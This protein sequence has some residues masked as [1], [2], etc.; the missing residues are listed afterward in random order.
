MMALVKEALKRTARW[1]ATIAALALLSI[2]AGVVLPRL[3]RFPEKISQRSLITIR[4]SG[5]SA[6]IVYDG[7]DEEQS[8]LMTARYIANLLGHFGIKPEIVRA[9]DYPAGHLSQFSAAF[10]IASAFYGP[11]P[12][13]LI[14]DAARSEKRICWLNRNIEQL[15]AEPG[16]AEKLGF[17]FERYV[18]LRGDVSVLFKGRALPK[19]DSPINIVS[20]TNPSKAEVLAL[21]RNGDRSVPY[22]IKSGN[23]WYFADAVFS[24]TVEADRSLVFSETLHDILGQQHGSS[25]YALVRI[26]DVNPESDPD[27]LRAVA[28]LLF[29]RGIPF[30]VSLIPIYKNPSRLV[31]IYL[32]DRPRVVEALQ[33]MVSRG[34][35]I[36]LHGVTHQLHGITSDDFEFWDAL[37][38]RP[39]REPG[40]AIVQKLDLGMEE[41]FRAGVFPIAWET[42]HYAASIST[43]ELLQRFFSHVY[44]RRMVADDRKTAQDLPY[45]IEDIYGQWVIPENLGYVSLEEPDPGAIVEGAERMLC[46]RDSIPSFFFHPFV[47]TSYLKTIVDGFK[48]HGYRF[49]SAEDFGCSVSIGNYAVS[50]V[51]KTVSIAA[52]QPFSRRITIDA[53]GRTSE[54]YEKVPPGRIVQEKLAPPPG[55]LAAVQDVPK[56]PAPKP[57]PSFGE[58]MRAWWKGTDIESIPIPQQVARRALLVVNPPY[59]DNSEPIDIRSFESFLRVYGIR[60]ERVE[61]SGF[62]NRNLGED[63]VVFVPHSAAG[64]FTESGKRKLAE[65]L[66]D[67]G[68]LVL[69]GMTNLAERVGFAYETRTLPVSKT[70]DSLFPDIDINWNR[71]VAMQR[72]DPPPVSTT[73]IEDVDSGR[74]VAVA[75]RYGEGLLIY[76]GADLDPETG[77]GYTRYPYLFHHLRNRMRLLSPVTAN[78]VE[79]YFDPGYRQ[80]APLER[81]V[82]SWHADGIRAVYAAA[83]HVYPNWKYDYDM[84]IR[85]CHERG[86]AVYAWFEFPQVSDKLWVT[87]PEWREKTVTG[88]DGQVGW[89]KQMNLA[90]K[91]CRAAAL[92]FFADLLT[93]H[94]WDGVNIAEISFDTRNG[95][96]DPSGY[97]PMNSDVRGTFK[98]QTGFDPVL[99]F[100]RKSPYY[101]QKNK[102]ALAKWEGY[103]AGLLN[104]LLVEFLDRLN[105]IRTKRDL[106]CIVT[107]LDSLHTPRITEKTGTDTRDVVALMNHYDF[108]LQIED[109][110][111][112]W[113]ALPNRYRQF[114]DTYSRL[115]KDPQRLMFDINVVTDRESRLAPTKLPAGTELALTAFSAAQSGNGRVA[116]Y[117]EASLQPEDRSLLPFVLGSAAGLSLKQN[118]DQRAAESPGARRSL[119]S[120]LIATE[121]TVRLSLVNE[122][123]KDTLYLGPAG[124]SSG[125]SYRM[126]REPGRML[127]L[128]N[129][130]WQCGREGEILIPVGEH[131]LGSAKLER[132][133][134]DRFG[135][136]LWVKDV[137][138]EV[139][140]VS[141]TTLGIAI[142]YASPRRA[143]V[144]LT[145][146]PKAVYIDGGE[147]EEPAVGRYGSEFLVQLPSGKHK[148][149]ID[150]QT[151]AS[152]VVDVASAVSAKSVV[153]IGGTLVLVLTILYIGVGGRRLVLI[154]RAKLGRI[155]H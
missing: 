79:F 97:V 18:D 90:N 64:G 125:T 128:D 127:L 150:D 69:E 141:R 44:D 35:S 88:K 123:G 37:T 104:E 134:A 65:W 6:L 12:Q 23:F 120:A 115:V 53:Q 76:V 149:L 124:D 107:S 142:E 152:V 151:T 132:G 119:E 143:W 1:K 68:R 99:L 96:L 133:L 100:D 30:Q 147:T 75:S 103:R 80:E 59:R 72:F 71:V 70:K 81:L 58:R 74:P 131:T 22:V 39:P 45:E 29:S 108:T 94:D 73:L 52:N 51:P 112:M 144:V 21:A 136:G 61:A 2:A 139:G 15:L 93:K 16:I 155:L 34:G 9:T 92:D 146:E 20:I 8:E 86:I 10:I 5:L 102:R 89:R 145:R 4:K 3:A 11:L 129:E 7:P 122:S 138:A 116:I 60:F 55:G 48:R 85:M 140:S 32:P 25:R 13:A 17:R 135:L 41:C 62:Q 42:P 113:G 50:T 84:L 126:V 66:H 148:V 114:A 101:W 54:S 24:Y 47:S 121:K 14:Q 57:K 46:V 36:I 33:Y 110:I 91:R 26:E 49:I 28:D 105:K 19:K 109:P 137:T 95:L 106:D 31:E 78:G 43:Y 27:Q 87:H 111:E 67:G 154:F 56:I 38:G 40:N 63:C 153:W 82:S 118:A 130:P 117:S 98:R 83:W 77:M